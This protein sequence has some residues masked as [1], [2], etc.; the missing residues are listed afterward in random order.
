MQNT[1]AQIRQVSRYAPTKNSHV[2]WPCWAGW[3]GYTSRA[4]GAVLERHS[5]RVCCAPLLM[6]MRQ[7]RPSLQF[8]VPLLKS[9]PVLQMRD[10]SSSSSSRS[11]AGR[12]LA[13]DTRR[14]GSATGDTEKREGQ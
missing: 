1:V 10:V 4:N 11:T 5:T 6:Y 3:P 7:R 2:G 13:R 9:V 12:T 8:S 14:L